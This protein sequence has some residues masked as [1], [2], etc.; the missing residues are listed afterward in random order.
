MIPFLTWARRSLSRRGLVQTSKVAG[1]TILDLSFDIWYGTDTMRWVWLEDLGA[2]SEHDANAVSY[3]ASKAR[4]L[5][6]LIKR[7]RLPRDRTFV[8][9]GSGKGRVLLLA[10]Q[11]KF[12]KVVGVEF[13]PKLCAIAR[14]NVA[15]FRWQLNISA[16]IDIIEADAAQ[17]SITPDQCIFYAFNPFDEIVMGA[18]LGSLRESLEYFPRQVWFIYNTPLQHATIENSGLFSSA[19]NFEIGG[20]EFKV[21]KN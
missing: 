12:Q 20:A 18:L 16:K 6:I 17:F 1:S 8:D 2:N 9:L 21:Y 13:S 15:R 4:P 3:R 14:A 5:C 10:A 7:L 19:E 11:L